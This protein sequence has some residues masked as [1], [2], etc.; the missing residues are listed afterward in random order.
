[1]LLDLTE[2][3]ACIRRSPVTFLCR[4]LSKRAEG[5]LI[6]AGVIVFDFTNGCVKHAAVVGCQNFVNR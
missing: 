3:M 1:M 6:P 4:F 2:R 5:A